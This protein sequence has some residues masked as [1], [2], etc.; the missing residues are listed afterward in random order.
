MA[1][2]DCHLCEQAV[3]RR[4]QLV[5]A[6]T[7]RRIEDMQTRA[8]PLGRFVPSWPKLD[9]DADYVPSPINAT[10]GGCGCKK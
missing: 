6:K 8:C 3:W 2:S 10:L 5:C 7:C 1:I 4:R 9:I